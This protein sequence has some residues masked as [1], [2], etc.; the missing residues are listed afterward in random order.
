MKELDTALEH[1]LCRSVQP[2][3]CALKRHSVFKPLVPRLRPRPPCSALLSLA[4]FLLRYPLS[5]PLLLL[6]ALE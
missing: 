5:L 2:P 1:K 6:V 3:P 4:D